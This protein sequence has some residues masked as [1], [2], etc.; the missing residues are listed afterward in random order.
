LGDELFANLFFLRYGARVKEGLHRCESA[1]I[2]DPVFGVTGVQIV[3]SSSLPK[4]SN[5]G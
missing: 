3:V 2:K 1:W 4:M 5:A